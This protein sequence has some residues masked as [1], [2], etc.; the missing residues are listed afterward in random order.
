MIS[1]GKGREGLEMLQK[2]LDIY[3][4]IGAVSGQ[5]NILFFVGTLLVSN[6]ELKKGIELVE[7]A[8]RLGEQID[9]KHPVT[10]YMKEVLEKMK[11]A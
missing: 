8:V 11:A 3:G 5:A 9:P 1:L 7:Q 6:G 4:E 2:A 10:R